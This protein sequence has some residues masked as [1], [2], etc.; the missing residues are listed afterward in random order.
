[1]SDTAINFATHFNYFQSPVEG[2]TLPSRFSYPFH[3]VPQ[4][5][6]LIAARELQDYLQT[7]TDWEHDFGMETSNADLIIGKMFGVLVVKNRQGDLGYLCAVSG[8]LAGQNLH[9]KFVPPVFD[10]LVQDGF[11]RKGEAIISE[12]NG[13]IYALEK[14]PDFLAATQQLNDAVNQSEAEIAA[15]KTNALEK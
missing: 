11:F 5:I 1:V 6:A 13:R 4:E 15:C 9:E 12:I 8:R 3:Y 2:I 7:Q 10:I 14:Q